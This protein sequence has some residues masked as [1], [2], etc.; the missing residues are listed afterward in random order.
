MCWDALCVQLGGTVHL[1]LLKPSWQRM[2]GRKAALMRAAIPRVWLC[3]SCKGP[4][5][6]ASWGES[7]NCTMLCAP[8]S[9]TLSTCLLP[10]DGKPLRASAALHIGAQQHLA[11]LGRPVETEKGSAPGANLVYVNRILTLT[12]H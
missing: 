7:P 2:G 11:R 9:G 4:E 6:R 3:Y 5:L 1:P 8:V 12:V 10:Q